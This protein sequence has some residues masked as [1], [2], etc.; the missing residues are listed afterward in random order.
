MNK[1]A[2][3]FDLDGTLSD[4]RHRLH[5]VE[6]SKDWKSFFK[7]MTEDPP[8]KAVI[9]ELFKYYELNY[10]IFILSGRPEEYKEQT[11]EWLSNNL[12]LP[13]MYGQPFLE[14]QKLLHMK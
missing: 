7:K 1:N 14:F 12:I 3:I 10:K 13:N 6:Q 8:V 5:Y 9:S 11:I 4:R 2:V